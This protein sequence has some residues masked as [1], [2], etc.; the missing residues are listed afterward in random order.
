MSLKETGGQNTS[1]KRK[2]KTMNLRK[3]LTAMLLVILCITLTL[4]GCAPAP[5]TPDA[6]TCTLVLS[7]GE[8]ATEYSVDLAAL[9][10]GDGAMPIITHLEQTRGLTYSKT[11]GMYGAYLTAIGSLKE[12]SAEGTYLGIWT[13][14]EAD[15]DVSEYATTVD[16]NGKTLVS[17]GVGISQMTIED[18]AV[19]Y[20]GYIHY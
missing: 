14:V 3:R 2:E 7:D 15:F 8:N 20:I 17:S 11:N 10:S 6:G 5:I 4:V 18:G 12:N 1:E 19:I 9:T 16:Y 13:S